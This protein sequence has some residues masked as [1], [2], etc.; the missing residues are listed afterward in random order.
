MDRHLGTDVDPPGRMRRDQH[1]GLLLDL[2]ADDEFLQIAAGQTVRAAASC[3]A[4]HVEPL[5]DRAGEPDG[6]RS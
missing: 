6:A 4:A 1:A 5:D 3:R 2:A